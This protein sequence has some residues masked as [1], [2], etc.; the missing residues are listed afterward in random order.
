[1]LI[2]PSLGQRRYYGILN[3]QSVGFNV[4][5]MGNTSSIVKECV[6]FNVTGV[7]I[8]TRQDGR[9]TPENV[10]KV[11]ANVGD[12]LSS[13][14]NNDVAKSIIENPYL[15]TDGVDRALGHVRS[16]LRKPNILRKKFTL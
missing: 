8:G 12:I 1:M 15:V 2:F 4:V 5:C 10:K 13:Y 6:F 7:L 14:D 3:L 16:N 9:L 11:P